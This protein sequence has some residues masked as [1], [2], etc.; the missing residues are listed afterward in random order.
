MHNIANMDAKDVRWDFTGLYDGPEDKAIVND[1]DQYDKMAADF[2]AKYKGKLST[3]LGKALVDYVEVDKLSNKLYIPLYLR[4]S[5]DQTDAA[6]R[7]SFGRSAE[8]LSTAGSKHFVFFN[9]EI[10]QMAEADYQNLLKTDVLVAQHQ[11]MLDKIRERAKH[12]LDESAESVVA[13]TS[14]F[15]SSDWSK[16]L[17]E[18]EADLRIEHN[19]KTMTLTEALDIMAESRDS[20]ERAAVMASVNTELKNSGVLKARAY[21]LNTV[22][23][24]KN[25]FD[26]KRGYEHVMSSRNIDNQTPDAV[27]DA[28]HK[29]VSTVGASYGKRYYKLLAKILGKDTLRWSDRNAQLPFAPETKVTW[30]EAWKMVVD[31]YR[32]FS[33]QM[34]D[35]LESIGAKGWIDVPTT[36]TKRGGAFLYPF[37]VPGEDTPQ[38]RIF[39]NFNGTLNDVSTLAHE[40]GHAVH[41][42]F[43][44]PK[45]GPLMYDTPM[46]YA[47]T[48]SIFAEMVT[49]T[50]LLNKAKDDK[51]KL[52]LLMGKINDGMNTVNRQ[53][54]F[55]NF[56][57]GFH[58]ARKNGD[59]SVD[60]FNK[61][62]MDKTVEMY[63]ADG[64]VFTYENIENMWAYVGHFMTPFYVYAYAFG[65]LF[66]QSLYAVKDDFGDKFEEMYIDLLAAGGTKS[67]EEMMKPFGLDPNDPKFWENGLHA[68]MGKMLDQAEEIATELGY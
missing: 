31:A 32:S 33:P 24:S 52:A 13:L 57:Q 65:E 35:H 20:D 45:Q 17:D 18:L 37:Y 25:A 29:A 42:Q 46:N 19:G 41:Y 30:P 23:G 64:E 66:T 22:A 43:S 14:P 62:W 63:G 60:D 49:F 11:P 58:E 54:S 7:K 15:V 59:L 6:V 16:Y 4:M 21:A 56:E 68:S 8:R 50:N 40:G 55:S 12:Q 27:V 48:A 28:L 10:G 51:E 47:E 3:L 61:L 34:A 39:L 36:D 1:L 53:I 44:G 26:T 5:C 67:A 38:S 2:E 9:I